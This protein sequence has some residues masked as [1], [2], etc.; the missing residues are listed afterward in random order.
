M[1]GLEDGYIST[2][3]NV[4]IESDL[5]MLDDI[6]ERSYNNNF[7]VKSYIIKSTD[8][9]LDTTHWNM[10]LRSRGDIQTQALF[11]NNGVVETED[12]DNNK[13]YYH[14]ITAAPYPEFDHFDWET[15]KV[16]RWGD[17]IN[18]IHEAE[19]EIGYFEITDEEYKDNALCDYQLM[20]QTYAW[21]AEHISYGAANGTKGQT[22]VEAVLDGVA[23]CAGYAR[24]FNR[25]MH[26]FG[27]DSYWVFEQPKT[28]NAEP[29]VSNFVRLNNEY[30]SADVNRATISKYSDYE[31]KYNQDE[32]IFINF[33]TLFGTIGDESIAEN[34]N[35]YY[36]S[37]AI[38]YYNTEFVNSKTSKFSIAEPLSTVSEDGFFE[39]QS[40]YDEYCIE[41]GKHHIYPV[42]NKVIINDYSN[43]I[44]DGS[45]FFEAKYRRFDY[46]TWSYVYEPSFHI[47]EGSGADEAEKNH[48]CEELDNQI[49]DTTTE[50]TT[51]EVIEVPTKP[52]DEITTNIDKTT[53]VEEIPTK[54]VETPVVQEPTTPEV[55]APT[56]EK[57]TTKQ[58]TIK[59]QDKVTRT[60]QS[61]T[62]KAQP[63]KAYVY[64][65]KAK[66]TVKSKTKTSLKVKLTCKNATKFKI[67]YITKT[68]YNKKVKNPKGKKVKAGWNSNKV[69]TKTISINKLNKKGCYTISRLKKN[70]TY[71]VRVIGIRTLNKKD[72]ISVKSSKVKTAM[73]AKK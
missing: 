31:N 12:D 59:N 58:E 39:K 43:R 4:A 9:K 23:V 19:K 3:E 44:V 37:K 18:A 36:E 25:F 5:I 50:E 72:Y 6:V 62:K 33:Y 28:P 46:D 26:D 13:I 21:M 67:Q 51:T 10:Y 14:S 30:Y 32:P 17:Y 15:R 73:T 61:T 56:T 71:K 68:A 40:M 66:V 45:Y 47:Y 53:S 11:D 34:S 49:V 54:P 35:Y 65:T 60:E 8:K 29:H 57:V 38:M 16:E 55:T 64:K 22:T 27:I 52:I 63:T 69:K 7:D 41:C 20:I 70:T 2:L 42:S 48:L 24:L 1:T